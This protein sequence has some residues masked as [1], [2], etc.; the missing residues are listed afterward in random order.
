LEL[1]NKETG[2]EMKELI[3]LNIK[4]KIDILRSQIV[5]TNINWSKKRFSPYV[6]E[7]VRE[8]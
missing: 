4:S 6:L 7:K 2:L 3:I 8:K 1:N 5:T